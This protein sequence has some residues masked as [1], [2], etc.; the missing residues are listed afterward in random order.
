LFLISAP[1]P[2][3]ELPV[4]FS[5]IFS[6]PSKAPPQIKRIFEVSI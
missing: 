3:A 1:K 2:R 4:R 6:I 5:T